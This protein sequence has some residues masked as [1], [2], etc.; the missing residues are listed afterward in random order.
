MFIG[1][2]QIH[3]GLE[4]PQILVSAE[5]LKAIPCKHQGATINKRC[6]QLGKNNPTR[7]GRDDFPQS[8]G[9]CIHL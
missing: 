4:C 7:S 8:S 6:F 1:Y 2:V 5:V 3:K 9:N